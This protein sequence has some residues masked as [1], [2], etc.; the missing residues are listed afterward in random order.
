MPDRGQ[1][2]NVLVGFLEGVARRDAEAY[3]RG[4][5]RRSLGTAETCWYAVEPL[6][7][8]YLYEIHEGGPGRSFLPDLAREIDAH[9]GGVALVPSG[10]RVLEVT[11]RNGRPV[12]ALLPEAK[13]RLV[14]TQMGLMMPTARTDGRPFGVLVPAWVT[15][16]QIRFRALQPSRRMKRLRRPIP[17]ELATSAAL[18]AVGFATLIGGSVSFFGSPARAPKPQVRALDAMPH[19]QWDAVLTAIGTGG[20]AAKLEYRSGRWTIES[21]PP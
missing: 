1:A 19:R 7:S 21:E 16:D 13:S 6:W 4:F 8:G 5:A 12:G 9:P 3:A 18:F 11:V 2:A 10:L 17:I 14:Q 15:K 20:Y